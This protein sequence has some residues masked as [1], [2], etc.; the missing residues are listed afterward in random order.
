MK[1]PPNFTEEEVLSVIDEVVLSLAPNFTFAYYDVEDLKQEGRIYAMEALPRYDASY[2]TTLKTFLYNHVKKRFLNLIRNKYQRTAPKGLSPERLEK[3]FKKN[4][5]KRSLLDTLDIS[6]ERN[7]KSDNKPDIIFGMANAEL[8][9]LID[10][11]LPVEYRGDYRCLM[12]DVKIPKVRRDRV[13]AVIKE[14]Y[15]KENR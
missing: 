11:H 7:E 12:E 2:K 4:S 6:D 5:V 1:L 13:I 10:I 8:F 14:I 3:W 9:T 15:E